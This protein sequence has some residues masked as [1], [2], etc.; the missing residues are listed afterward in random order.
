MLEVYD[1]N[2]VGLKPSQF[3]PRPAPPHSWR[4]TP[5]GPCSGLV[6]GTPVDAAVYPRPNG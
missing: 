5:A 2:Q 1:R 6:P 3:L 4:V